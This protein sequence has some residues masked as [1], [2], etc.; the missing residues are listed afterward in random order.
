MMPDSLRKTVVVFLF[1]V[2]TPA[3]TQSST[4]AQ[5]KERP[6]PP[7]RDPLTPGY[8]QAKELPDGVV[9]SGNVDGNFIIGATHSAASELSAPEKALQG[10]VLEFTMK[11]SDSKIFPGIARDANTCGAPDPTDPAKLYVTTSRPAPYT[12]KVAVYVPKQYAP[13]TPA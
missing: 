11:S 9:P 10:T 7:T 1:T 8:V 4:T 5:S 2:A 6:A 3:F 12:R 13:D